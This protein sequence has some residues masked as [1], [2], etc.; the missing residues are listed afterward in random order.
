METEQNQPASSS[1]TNFRRE[2]A[3]AEGPGWIKVAAFVVVNC[4]GSWIAWQGNSAIFPGESLALMQA[5]ICLNL[6]AALVLLFMSGAVQ[7]NVKQFA[8][9]ALALGGLALWAVV[10]THVYAAR[11]I[12]ASQLGQAERNT[13]ELFS[14]KLRQAE[15]DARVREAEANAEL[16]KRANNLARRTGQAPKI[17]LTS[18]SPVPVPPVGSQATEASPLVD[19]AATPTPAARVLTASEKREGLLPLLTF[20]ILL[21]S[22]CNIGGVVVGLALW[23]YTIAKLAGKPAMGK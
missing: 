18:P 16:L 6:C 21:E 4:L 17:D 7:K 1:W 23:E 10:F 13:Q 15:S 3:Q 5:L 2:I 8:I 11:E 19:P 20:F 14:F 9:I 22:L 12:G